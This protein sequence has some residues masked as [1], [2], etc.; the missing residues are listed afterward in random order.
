[1]GTARLVLL[2]GGMFNVS[3]AMLSCKRTRAV[4][5][6][7]GL[8]SYA[9]ACACLEANDTTFRLAKAW[10]STIE[11]ARRTFDINAADNLSGVGS[12]RGLRRR[13]K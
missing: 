9:C 3:E 8:S 1:M 10:Q 2:A 12:Y 6:S 11:E 5:A 4:P 13:P 7:T